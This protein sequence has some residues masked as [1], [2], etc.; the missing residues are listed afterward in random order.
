ME[1]F[2][3]NEHLYKAVDFLKERN[4]EE[5]NLPQNMLENGLG[6]KV[7]DIMAAN[8]LGNATYL[9]TPLSFAH[10]DPPTPWITW[11]MSMWNARLNQN[12]LHQELSPFATKA[13]EL[14]IEWIKEYFGMDGG[15][16]C[17]GS[18]IA[19][20][21]ALWVA[22]DLKG[23]DTI[24]ASEASHISIVKAAKILNMK[25]IKVPTNIDGSI[26]E[27]KL[28]EMKNA[29]LVLNVGTTCMGAIDNL[30]LIGKAKWTHIDAAYA[31]ALKFSA[32][33]ADIL[34]GVE[35]ADSISLSSHKWLYQPKDSAIVLFKDNKKAKEIM[36]FGSSYLSSSNIGI[37]GSKGANGVILL[38]TL[39]YFGKKGIEKLLNNSM[40]NA[41]LFYEK[42][43]E[44]DE[45]E[46]FKKPVTGITLF[47]PKA[48]EVNEF[49]S[50][51][52]KGVFSK[53]KVREIEYVRSVALN[54]MADIEKIIDLIKITLKS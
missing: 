15:H 19:N 5:K 53:C 2:K 4:F 6:G 3:F 12:L 51:L 1:D 35:R 24:I 22:R 7:V 27:E 43:K 21:T 31:G 26:D 50:N 25:L 39:L 32:R 17:N 48:M 34:N 14:V 40:K 16:M 8:V 13:E 46:L 45:I 10:M 18:S 44:I 49:L 38:A 36:G 9:D 33:Y 28:P 20:L 52:P 29:V 41:N 42:L 23:I 11:I 30:K 37:Q 47:R 54:P